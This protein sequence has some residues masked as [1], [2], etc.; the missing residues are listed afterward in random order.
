MPDGTSEMNTDRMSC[1]EVREKLPLYAGGDLDPDILEAVHGHLDL[2]GECARRAARAMGARRVLVSAFRAQEGD[3]AQPGLWP[4][5]RARLQAEG[6]IQ[7]AGGAESRPVLRRASRARWAWALAPLAAAAALLLFL[8][9]GGELEN[10]ASPGG[11]PIPPGPRTDSAPGMVA[12]PV[13]APTRGSLQRI[14]P[15]A[16]DPEVLLYQ[17]QRRAGSRAPNAG[18]ISLAGYK[19]IK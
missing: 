13:S 19:R 7:P 18:G 15:A 11:G 1:G 3:V 5:I 4:G 16:E 12:T 2:C 17:G 14:D 8:Q 9:A 6:L 10:G